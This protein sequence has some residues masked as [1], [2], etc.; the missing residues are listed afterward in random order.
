M[1]GLASGGGRLPLLCKAPLARSR[2]FSPHP[3][4][5]TRVPASSTEQPRS[6]LRS[7]LP[8]PPAPLPSFAPSGLAHYLPE[9][10][11]SPTPRP[12]LSSTS[13]PPAR[14]GV[15]NGGP[16]FAGRLVEALRGV[17]GSSASALG[18]WAVR[19]SLRPR[20]RHQMVEDLSWSDLWML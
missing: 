16:D 18:C 11:A 12:L 10:P 4:L 14:A 1:P 15:P 3:A 13:F 5:W 2:P 20:A 19:G 7:L 17:R 6:S 8:W 9:A